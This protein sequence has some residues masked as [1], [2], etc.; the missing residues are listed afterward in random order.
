MKNDIELTFQT[1]DLPPPFANAISIKFRRE[2]TD[3]WIDFNQE[4]LNREAIS[5]EEIIEE[6]FSTNDDLA[7]KGSLN[8]SWQRDFDNLLTRTSVSA[9]A[10]ESGN[11]LF[12]TSEGKQ[13]F[14]D[15]AE[16]WEYFIQEVIQAIYERSGK[17]YEFLMI[18][19]TK[20][21]LHEIKGSFA[22][23][24]F[25]VNEAEKD[26]TSFHT[27]LIL[28][29][30]IE[31]AENPKNTGKSHTPSISFNKKDYFPITSD[32]KVVKEMLDFIGAI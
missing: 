23:R 7:W 5:E 25:T 20:D 27:L 11:T 29:E 10:Q 19:R 4:Y 30:K 16:A 15:N 21:T 17:E 31:L 9:K 18:I 12:L 26:W 13:G 8:H 14:I 2:N 1:V 28:L 6:G 22:Q 32:A 3:L 24:L